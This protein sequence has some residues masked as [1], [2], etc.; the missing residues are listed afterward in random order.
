MAVDAHTIEGDEDA[1]QKILRWLKPH[2]ASSERQGDVVL[3]LL[4]LPADK[5]KD[6]V[7]PDVIAE[8]MTFDPADEDDDLESF[9]RRVIDEAIEDC[10]TAGRGIIKY[11]V[12]IDGKREMR[13]FNL[14]NKPPKNTYEDPLES[15]FDPDDTTAEPPT[16]KGQIALA[17]DFAYRSMKLLVTKV[18]DDRVIDQ[19]D[20]ESMRRRMEG[21]EK[22]LSDNLRVK[23]IAL[24]K[25]QERRIELRKFEK[26]EERKEKFWK[27]TG[28]L[29]VPALLA[30]VGQRYGL[31]NALPPMGGS[32][33]NGGAPRAPSP[34]GAPRRT[35]P[36]LDAES[37]VLLDDLFATFDMPAVQR[38]ISSD[39]ITDEV[40]EKFMLL[41][42]KRLESH[43]AAEGA[44]GQAPANGTNGAHKNGS[45]AAAESR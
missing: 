4:R 34:N 44:A 24:S 43:Q 23:E 27:T 1:Y 2:A 26:S 19:R 5:Y 32:G 3:R 25:E 42:Q 15:T 36:K 9:V 17:Q 37:V 16:P 11:A 12:Q 40:R 41:F 33:A 31:P 6:E 38:L 13:G 45:P 28:E 22:Q 20:K 39:L 35:D 14:K 8:E 18:H 30:Y 7:E 10:E 21:L 29:V